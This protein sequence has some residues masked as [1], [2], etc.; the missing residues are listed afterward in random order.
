MIL[1]QLCTKLLA[2]EEFAPFA[3]G[4]AK[5][6][7]LHAE[8]FAP[9]SFP[10]IIS[11]VFHS[12]KKQL[13]VITR[14][15]PAMQELIADLSAF[16]DPSLIAPFPSWEM[17]PYEYVSPA[18]A[19][20]RDRITT[21]FKL[22]TG[23]RCIAVCTAESLLR[24][25]PSRSFLKKK[26]I[27]LAAGDDYPFDEIVLAL[28]EYGYAREHRVE[29]YGQFA[30]KGG[31]IDIFLPSHENPVRLDFF[32]D[33]LESIREFD[34]ETQTSIGP[35][36][37]VKLYPRKELVLSKKEIQDLL[38]KIR[39][40]SFK[41]ADFPEKL[42][43]LLES[44]DVPAG[45]MIP[46]IEELFPLAVH[47]ESL[48]DYLPEGTVVIIAEY[49]EVMAEK[50]S[51]ISIYSELYDRKK[52]STLCLETDKLLFTT[53]AEKLIARGTRLQVFVTT[54]E[55]YQWPIRSIPSFHGK[56]PAVREEITK[57]IADGW[58]IIILTAFEGQA[59]RLADLFA[60]AQP[61]SSFE[62]YDT[63]KPF[64][65]LLSPYS[66][67]FESA[68]TKTLIL[69]DHDI[70][71]KSYRKKKSFKGKKSRALASFLEL[72]PGDSVV[73]INHGIGIFRSIERMTAGG[74]ERDFLLLEYAG[75]D[76]LYVSLDQLTM[77]QKYIGMDGKA[78]RIDALGKNSAWNRIKERVQKSVEEIAGELIQIYAKRKALKGLQ[79]P[80]DTLWQEEFESKFE[81]EET[82]DQLTAIE[83]VKDDMEKPLP[84]DRLVCGDV[85][86]GKTEV[87]IRAAFKAV[88]AGRQVA[89]LAP[90][91]ILAMQHFN[92]F[93][94]RFE[95]YPVT[96]DMM[97]RFRTAAEIK[98]TKAAINEGKVDI[99]VGTHALLAKDLTFKNIGLLV[100]DEEQRFGVKHKEQIKKFRSQ[101]DVLTL[102]ATPIPRTLHMSMAG[103]RDLSI[104]ATPPENR[105][106]VETYVMEENPD[107][108]R[109]AIRRELDRGGQIFYV[110]NRVQTIEVQAAMLRELVPA[111]RIA[112]AHGQMGDDELE[113]I[114]AAF[115]EGQFDIL[116]ATTIIES[117][118]DMPHVNTIIIDRADTFG[119]SQL[120]QLKGRVGRSNRQGYAYLFYPKH[121]ALNE[122]AEKR[123]QVIAEHTELGSG[124]KIAM[125]DLEIRGAG[126][127]LGQEQSGNIMDVGFDLYCQMLEEAVR[128]LKGEK[129][130]RMFRTPVYLNM[131]MFIPEDYISDEKQK[132]EF[133]KR[134]EGCENTEEINAI[135]KEISD[136]FGEYPKEVA[137]LIELQR[138]RALASTLFID[139]ILEDS[140]NIK[141]RITS[142]SSADI[143]KIIKQ[144]HKDQRFALD[145]HEPELLRF[146]PAS[147]EPEKK[148][149]ELKKWLQQLS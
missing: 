52:G 116:L 129:P 55:S 98:K 99:V 44:D 71:G 109:M 35:V 140:Y 97:S 91:T 39:A 6:D 41:D 54:P 87:A 113:D 102:S 95:S 124:F 24:A 112:V 10:F 94:K 22:A 62:S 60:D 21:L 11:S 5:G 148:I 34:A 80:P 79:F 28:A 9:S 23:E 149:E 132:I 30:V 86:F 110:H 32:G 27:V 135:E 40:L 68:P 90:T 64:H 57:R 76:K 141:I 122:I 26:E 45:A 72:A 8:G 66:A 144:I 7:T 145:K 105:L 117:G 104:I 84:M 111:A 33:T 138:V 17:L 101:V 125:K 115:L 25:V 127:I 75:G 139:E 107:I 12:I 47:A 50:E 133:Y 53:E 4:V 85:G 81:Y 82:P 114:M 1:E 106:S 120:Y 126:N 118:L 143:G 15:P 3:Q 65:I 18:E 136:R 36:D 134:L 130:L 46:G 51:I 38:A 37:E 123:L 73:H 121:V 16:I 58:E 78:P 13:L 63:K 61:G 119:L 29:G 20:E 108:A 56:I 70:F 89:I 131:S 2:S 42:K 59:R 48:S 88:M 147:Q 69:T 83:D 19:I 49:P 137:L 146:K 14:N 128:Q 142:E 67:G 77:V 103:M 93:K 100:I 74:V 43:E 92:T 96:I 31:I